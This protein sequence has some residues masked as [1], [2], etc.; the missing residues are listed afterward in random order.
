MNECRWQRVKELFLAS[1]ELPERA[2]I[3]LLRRECDGDEQ[4]RGE[5]E[6]LLDKH[7]ETSG[8]LEEPPHISPD[9]REPRTR[10]P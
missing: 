5:V 7:D 6:A 3:R 9:P 2:R 1:I 4:L 10:A 8:F